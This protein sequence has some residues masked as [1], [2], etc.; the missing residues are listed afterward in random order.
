M[1]EKEHRAQDYAEG[2]LNL[3]IN[4]RKLKYYFNPIDLNKTIIIPIGITKMTPSLEVR[5]KYPFRFA[6]VESGQKKWKAFTP[7]AVEGL[8]EIPYLIST[9]EDLN[10]G[11]FR[12]NYFILG[13]GDAQTPNELLEAV[14]SV[15]QLTLEVRGNDTTTRIIEGLIGS[16]YD[17]KIR[18]IEGL[19]RSGY[20]ITGVN[21]QYKDVAYDD[22]LH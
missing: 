11:K 3:K 20:L 9:L 10:N 16:G 18:I 14:D 12:S 6:V 17:T 5:T 21:S 13:R 22:K 2:G 1:A 7:V 8:L 4:F 15:V 19:I